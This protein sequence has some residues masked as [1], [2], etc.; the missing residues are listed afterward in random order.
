MNW[1]IEVLSSVSNYIMDISV[2]NWILLILLCGAISILFIFAFVQ[3]ISPLEFELKGEVESQ[4]HQIEDY[5]LEICGLSDELIKEKQRSKIADETI[6]QLSQEKQKLERDIELQSAR[7]AKVCR[8]R[9]HYQDLYNDW[10][11]SHFT[12]N[13]RNKEAM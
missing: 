6:W 11:D 1:L 8:E 13:Q 4:C 5:E 12:V 10:A 3:S 7:Y 9:D 2:T